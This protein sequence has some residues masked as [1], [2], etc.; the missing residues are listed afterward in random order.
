MRCSTVLT[1]YSDF[2]HVQQV[3]RVERT[4]W[5]SASSATDKPWGHEVSFYLSDLTPAAAA[6]RLAR[7]APEGSLPPKSV[8]QASN[9]YLGALIR[10]HWGIESLHWVRDRTF[11]E[12][13]SQAHCGAGPQVMAAF[14]NCA[15]G[16]LHRLHITTIAAACRHLGRHSHTVATI[17]GL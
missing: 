11:R 16:L 9:E 1:G 10:G 5:K 8:T 4:T 6:A 7:L 17:L 2:P 12:D 13:E 14:R 3:V 15:I